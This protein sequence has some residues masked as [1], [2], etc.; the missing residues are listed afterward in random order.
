MKQ[1]RRRQLTQRRQGTL[2]WSRSNPKKKSFQGR[3]ED[4]LARIKTISRQ[5]EALFK[6][7]ADS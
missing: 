2:H 5:H 4:A 1:R 6:R 3:Q 7:L